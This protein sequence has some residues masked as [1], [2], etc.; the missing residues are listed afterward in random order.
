ML[1][2]RVHPTTTP[3]SIYLPHDIPT[4]YTP[5][6]CS[7]FNHGN[8]YIYFIYK[9]PRHHA[10]SFLFT[11]THAFAHLVQVWFPME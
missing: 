3:L 2:L 11:N 4:L 9:D 7:L 8:T 1:P 5:T 6:P 10:P